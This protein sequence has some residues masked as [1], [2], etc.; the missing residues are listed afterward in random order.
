MTSMNV[1][2]LWTEDRAVSPVVGVALL[3]AITVILAAVIGGVVLGLG[4]SSAEAPQASLQFQFQDNT[5]LDIQHA[6]GDKLNASNIEIRTSDGTGVSTG[7]DQN[8]AA[9]ETETITFSSGLDAGDRVSVVWM[10]PNSEDEA[11]LGSA[12]YQP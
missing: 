12:E 4:S 6:G 8:T 10:D 11:I 9:G 3:I 1:H 7:F 5:T 2:K